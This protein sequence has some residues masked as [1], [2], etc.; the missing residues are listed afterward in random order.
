MQNRE[1]RV[2]LSQDVGEIQPGGRVIGL[3]TG[4]VQGGVVVETVLP[5]ATDTDTWREWGKHVLKELERLDECLVRM[6][7][8]VS[9]LKRLAV[10][11]PEL[12]SKIELLR[13]RMHDMRN[14]LTILRTELELGEK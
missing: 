7:Q 4:P 10:Q 9:E 12:D 2:E 1:T 5:T 13:A 11:R 6:G 8:E 3:V 14:E